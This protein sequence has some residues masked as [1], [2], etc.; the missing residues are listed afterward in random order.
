MCV[1]FFRSFLLYLVLL[2]DTRQFMFAVM[3]VESILKVFGGA[4]PQWENL[5]A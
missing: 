3:V 4:G 5:I 2:R 1:W